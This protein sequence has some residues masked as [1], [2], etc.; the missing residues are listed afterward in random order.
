MIKSTSVAFAAIFSVYYLKNKLYRQH[1]SAIALIIIGTALVGVALI[2]QGGNNNKSNSLVTG[3]ILVLIG[4][5][6][7]SASYTAEEKIMRL[8]PDA[9]PIQIIA[10]EGLFCG[11]IWLVLLPCL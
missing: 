1:F 7:G 2:I 3:I 4:N 5:F 8:Y 9:D 11:L 10:Y 6:F